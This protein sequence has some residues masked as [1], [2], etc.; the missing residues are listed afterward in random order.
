MELQYKFEND[1]ITQALSNLIALG[2]S[3]GLTRKIANVLW[4]ESETAFDEERSPEGKAWKALNKQ[5]QKRRYKKGYT[6]NI[7]QVSGDLVNSLNIDYG[8]NFA[9]VGVAEN[10]GQYH[11]LGT[12]YMEARPF[13]GLGKDGEDEIYDI[14][15]KEIKNALGKS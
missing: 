4:Q 8:T 2:K 11:Q 10:Y 13:L 15:R 6:G 9:L 5:Y 12:K 14:I 3:D 7:L 1:Q